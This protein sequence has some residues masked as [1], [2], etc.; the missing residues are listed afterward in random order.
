MWKS[1]GLGQCARPLRSGRAATAAERRQ[2]TSSWD[3]GGGELLW[4]VRISVAVL[5]VQRELQ[6]AGDVSS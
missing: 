3:V 2:S 4:R 5:L 1:K 6:G